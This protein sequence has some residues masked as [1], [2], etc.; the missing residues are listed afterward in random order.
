MG[1]GVV[2]RAFLP[3]PD[4]GIQAQAGFETAC[5]LGFRWIADGLGFVPRSRTGAKLL[6]E[7]FSRHY[8][9]LSIL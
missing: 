2:V 1:G 3:P 8:D 9:R 7:V 6:F 4:G 5:S